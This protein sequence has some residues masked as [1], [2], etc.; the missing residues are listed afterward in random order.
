[1]I[2]DGHDHRAGPGK[3]RLERRRRHAVR[4]RVLHRRQTGSVTRYATFA[5]RYRAMTMPVPRASDSGMLR[6]GSRTSPAVKVMLFHASAEKSDPVCDTQIATNNPN[7][8]AAERPGTMSRVPAPRPELAEVVGDR[9][10]VPAEEQCR[11]AISPTQRAGFR[12]GENVLD[13]LAVFEPARVRPRQQRDEQD[14]DELRRRQRERVAGAEVHRRHQVVILGDPRP[15]HA[16][17][18]READRHGRDRAGLDDQEQRPAVE[19]PPQRRER[20]AQV[21]VLA[22]GARHHRRQFAVGQ[23]ADDRQHAGH[24]PRGQQPSGAPTLPRHVGRHDEDA[25][26]DHRADDDHR[27]VEEAEASCEFVSRLPDGDV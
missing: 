13:D 6:R 2:A 20:F 5:S 14:A 11:R 1:M 8:V 12:R 16:E 25:G 19:E 4:R 24:D 7:A 10:V 23:R 17:V 21:D 22:A 9:V 18:T 3:D 26:P 15:Q 27:G